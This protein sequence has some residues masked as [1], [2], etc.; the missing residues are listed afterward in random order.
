MKDMGSAYI[1]SDRTGELGQTDINV[2][3]DLKK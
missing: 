1:I 3:V 2:E